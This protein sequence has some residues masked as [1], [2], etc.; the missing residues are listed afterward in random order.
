MSTQKIRLRARYRSVQVRASELDG[1]LNAHA[2]LRVERPPELWT[3]SVDLEP[4]IRLLGEMIAAALARN[5]NKLEEITLNVSNVVVE[6]EAAEP[7]PEGGYVAVTIRSRGD[8]GPET[9]WSPGEATR[10]I[11]PDLTVALTT[12]NASYAY[13]RALA[14]GEGSITVFFAAAGRR[15]SPP[16]RAGAP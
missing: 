3:T 10:M 7:A 4:F 14:D 5:G 15:G 1:I 2:F 9:R 6:P 13:T 11:N 12:A 16:F 8:W